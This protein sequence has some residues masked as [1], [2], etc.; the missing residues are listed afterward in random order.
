VILNGRTRLVPGRQL[1]HEI[2]ATGGDVL[3]KQVTEDAD[4]MSR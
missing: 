3:C 2:V 1:D 4:R